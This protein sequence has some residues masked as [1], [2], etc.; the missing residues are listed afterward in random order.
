MFRG[1]VEANTQSIYFSPPANEVMESNVFSCV[2]QCVQWGGGPL[3]DS[4]TPTGH[5]HTCSTWTS[6]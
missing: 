6:L 4:L 3:L 2:C 1:Y 5:V